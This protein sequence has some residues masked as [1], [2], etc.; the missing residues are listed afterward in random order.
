MA[1]GVNTQSV[2]KQGRRVYW[3]FGPQ[4]ARRTGQGQVTSG[5]TPRIWPIA[6]GSSVLAVSPVIS[7]RRA[8]RLVSRLS[9]T[10]SSHLLGPAAE[11][12]E[13]A[14]S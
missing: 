13:N 8:D 14:E 2:K 3:R 7:I 9:L 5:L 10:R 1:D 6:A 11:L 12:L 4:S